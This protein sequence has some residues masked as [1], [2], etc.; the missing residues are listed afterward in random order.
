MPI[1]LTP[2]S[3]PVTGV[4]R[5]DAVLMEI[6][7]GDWIP[8]TEAAQR[9]RAAGIPGDLLTA[10]VRKGRRRGVLRTERAAEGARVMRVWSEP[11]RPS[12][13]TP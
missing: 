4:D 2:D 7:F 10:T 6:P 12:A 11:R 9:L 13:P 5:L 3:A 1:T 8:M